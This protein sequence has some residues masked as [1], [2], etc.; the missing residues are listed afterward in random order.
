MILG[1]TKMDMSVMT[2]LRSLVDTEV[3]NEIWV[4]DPDPTDIEYARTKDVDVLAYSTGGLLILR[5]PS[6]RRL[7]LAT[8]SAFSGFNER[9]VQANELVR[10]KCVFWVHP[11][12][13]GFVGVPL[14]AENYDY[15]IQTRLAGNQ[16]GPL[17]RKGAA[18]REQ[19]ARPVV[20][21]ADP[22]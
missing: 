4:P 14:R 21:R 12:L 2:D 19:R 13:A 17:N 1:A 7:R 11:E 3:V 20:F 6:S 8:T 16:T 10:R 15:L 22:Q 18:P 5:M 9:M